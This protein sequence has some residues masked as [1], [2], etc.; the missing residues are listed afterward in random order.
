[1]AWG[2]NPMFRLWSFPGSR[3]IASMKIIILDDYADSVRSLSCFQK[4]KGHD[5]RISNEVIDDEARLA[6]VIADAEAVVLIRQRSRIGAS[7]LARLPALRFISQTGKLG[8][9][10]DED[11][12]T[13]RGVAISVTSSSAYATAEFAW[14]LILAARR[15]IAREAQA[16]RQ[17]Q[18][19]T[20]LGTTVRG[21]TLGIFGYG[22][23]GKLVA[24]HG[25]AFGMRILA[26]GR[27]G[28]AARAKAD[29]VSMAASQRELFSN[30]D[31]VSVHL[32]LEAATHGIVGADDLAAMKPDSLFVNT[33]RAELV[34][35]GALLSALHAGRP[36]AAAVDVYER[37]P[38]IGDP[39]L[40]LPNVLATPHL[41]Y[42]ERDSYE[43]YFGEAFDNVLAF[44]AGVP[45]N[46]VNP[47][48]LAH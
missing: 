34:A 40:A 2:V 38:A 29:D 3:S 45:V 48:A 19:Q 9:H 6:E 13:R 43:F 14:G 16:L 36:G 11:A 26:F 39:L 5:V 47:A 31:V 20:M 27:A 15:G 28:S 44:A 22:K 17:G 35:P 24:D 33:S 25:K 46:V 21:R 8:V 41:G 1:M 7:T 37:E 10:V 4:L 18:W 42:V 23:I 32:R 12:C 30:S